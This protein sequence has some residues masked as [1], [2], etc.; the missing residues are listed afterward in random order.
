MAPAVKRK[1][2]LPVLEAIAEALMPSQPDKAS[3]ARK[4]GKQDMANLYATSGKQNNNHMHQACQP[5]CCTVSVSSACNDCKYLY[6]RFWHGWRRTSLQNP[7]KRS[8]CTSV[9]LSYSLTSSSSSSPSG[10]LLPLQLW[11][12]AIMPC[13]GLCIRNSSIG[14]CATS[15]CSL[16]VYQMSIL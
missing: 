1:A 9:I 4:E 13:S 2:L 10:R 5:C 3:V 11:L 14:I 6:C 7:R 8:F 12:A 15:L 16:T